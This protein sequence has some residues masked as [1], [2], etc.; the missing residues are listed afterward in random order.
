MNTAKSKYVRPKVT[1]TDTI[2]TQE[3][4][5]ALLENYIKIENIDEIPLGTFVKYITFTNN[6][7][8]LCIG[9]RLYK[10]HK[11]YIMLK[12]RNHVLFSVQKYHWEKNADKEKD[13]PIFITMF[14]KNKL[15]KQLILIKQLKNTILSL[16][17]ENTA[18]KK[19]NKEIKHQLLQIYNDHP[20]LF[21]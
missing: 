18:L 16:E 17:L 10:K 13:N 3:K 8:R 14:W 20:E 4:I 12:G 9:G 5:K 6:R 7:P 2:Q 19:Q 11:D 15:D 1:Y 21:T